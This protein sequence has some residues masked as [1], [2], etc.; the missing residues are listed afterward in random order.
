M[1]TEKISPQ[2]INKKDPYKFL[3]N[4]TFT[5]ES[6]NNISD[7]LKLGEV[8]MGLDKRQLK[9]FLNRFSTNWEIQDGALVFTPLELEA[10]ATEDIDPLLKEIY[11]DPVMSL[12]KGINA[13]YDCIRKSYVGITRKD[14]T[15]F[16]KLQ[17][18]Y[19]LTFVKKKV[20]QKPIYATYPNEKWGCDL[21]DMN[22][23][24][25]HNHQYRYILTVID[26]FSRKSF[27]TA[28]K[29]KDLSATIAGFDKIIAEQTN[30]TTPNVIVCDNGAEF[31]LSEWCKNHGIKLIHTQSHTPTQNSLIENFNGSLRRIIR[32]NFV[33]TNSL[34]WVDD[35]QMMLDNW[36]N[37]KHGTTAYAPN[38]LWKH[39]NE[40]VSGKIPDIEEVGLQSQDQK[41]SMVKNK[42]AARAEQQIEALK[43]QSL[44]VG[45]TVRVRTEAL[46][47]ELRK[48]IKAHWQKLITIKFSTKIYVISKIIKARGKTTLALDKYE[49]KDSK[50]K[51]LLEEFNLKYPNKVLKPRKMN[52]TDLMKVD[53]NTIV[54]R[55][56]QLETKLNLLDYDA[57]EDEQ[58]K[59]PTRKSKR[60][61]KINK[62]AEKEANK[63]I[64]V[65]PTRVS[66][67]IRKPKEVLDL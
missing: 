31:E 51:V 62:D 16:L 42:T 18:D 6:I 58:I 41:I 7:F 17:E 48:T 66:T 22:Q 43:K 19:Q 29:T 10:I 63:D 28:L 27:A 30:G 3:N 45:D 46:H 8:P 60:I 34:V 2:R 56:K 26:F 52:I 25:S 61:E 20:A 37:K 23:Y 21:I 36:N 59:L 55:N 5:H 4:L 44:N 57:I 67:R 65:E 38:E 54:S 1:A 39:G 24:V 9:K 32:A 35:L 50:G 12:A 49:L 11:A 47:S 13:F 14:V 53:K 33:R 64:V 15:N 40:R